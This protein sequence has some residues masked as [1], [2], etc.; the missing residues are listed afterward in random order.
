MTLELEQSFTL[1][2]RRTPLITITGG[3]SAARVHATLLDNSTLRRRC[4]RLI[5]AAFSFLPNGLPDFISATPVCPARLAE[6]M[7]A[8]RQAAI[9]DRV[10]IGSVCVMWPYGWRSSRTYIT[11]LNQNYKPAYFSKV[12]T[13]ASDYDRFKHESEMLRRMDRM[14]LFGWCYPTSRGVQEDSGRTS[15]VMSALPGR[16]Q[17]YCWKHIGALLPLRKSASATHIGLR[18]ISPDSL[19]WMQE[20][21]SISNP[22]FSALMAEASNRPI[23][24][25]LAHGDIRGNNVTRVGRRYW[26][27]D[28]ETASF[29]APM[30]TDTVSYLVNDRTLRRRV[31]R[32]IARR[33]STLKLA[34]FLGYDRTDVGLALLY[35]AYQGNADARHM[36]ESWD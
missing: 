4:V 22:R 20:A 13:S 3:I 33:T 7:Y 26:L 32:R 28:W 17:S 35:L 30:L 36:I 18:P 6:V 16:R 34:E 5:T 24:C 23:M 14:T 8:I 21:S 11:A 9:E 31:G 25:G 1:Y 15:I 27:L 12:S 29:N 2:Y 10:E 19:P